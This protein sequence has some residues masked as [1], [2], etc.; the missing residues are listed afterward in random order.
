MLHNK[1]GKWSV[2]FLVKLPISGDNQD[3]YLMKFGYMLWLH[4][5]DCDLSLNL[6]TFGYNENKYFL[7]STSFSTFLINVWRKKEEVRMD[8]YLYPFG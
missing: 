7:F 1:A 3:I 2:L 6:E 8:L 5:C 4:Y